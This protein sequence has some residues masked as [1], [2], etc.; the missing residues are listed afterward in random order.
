MSSMP[1]DSGKPVGPTVP[2]YESESVEGRD[3]LDIERDVNGLASLVAA[4]QVTPPLSIGL[5]GPWGSG[6]SFFMAKLRTRISQLADATRQREARA[7][8]S[9]FHG[10]VVQI[11]FNA[12]NYIEADLWASLVTHI[13]EQLHHR[14]V[15]HPTER[16]QWFKLLQELDDAEETYGETQR[17]REAA[18]SALADAHDRFAAV[19]LSLVKRIDVWWD[20]V[21]RGDAAT[22]DAISDELNT[23]QAGLG[24]DAAREILRD[25]ARHREDFERI[26]PRLPSFWRVAAANFWRVVGI[27]VVAVCIL[28]TLAMIVLYALAQLPPGQAWMREFWAQVVQAAVPIVAAG[29]SI[30][31]TMAKVVD[32]NKR[33]ER[34]RGFAQVEL[35]AGKAKRPEA[36]ALL[37]AERQLAVAAADHEEQQRTVDQL[38]QEERAMR[39]S[40]RLASFLEDRAGSEDYRKYLGVPAMIRRDF[41]KLH[42]LLVELREQSFVLPADEAFW[43]DLEG[44]STASDDEADV[45]PSV[46]ELVD[47]T[48]VRLRKVHVQRQGAEAEPV[49]VVREVGRPRTI[50]LRRDGDTARGEI[51]WALPRIDRI[52]LYI[53]D[54]DRCPA[55]RV[56][57]VLQ[58]VHM[59]L[60]F[61]LFVVVVGV[62]ARWISSSLD[63]EHTDLFAMGSV[64]PHDYLEKI[65]QIPYWIEPIT[66][67]GATQM[68][69]HFLAP[70]QDRDALVEP[71]PPVELAGNE[72]AMQAP[73]LT[74]HEVEI[75]AVQATAGLVGR[76]P[77]AVKRYLNAYR[78]LRTRLTPAELEQFVVGDAPVPDYRL[79]VVLLAVMVGAPGVAS[80]LFPKIRDEPA[81]GRLEAAAI[82]G[83]EADCSV[84]ER[85]PSVEL[86]LRELAV[87]GG[88]VTYGRLHAVLAQV[89]RLSFRFATPS[90][91]LGSA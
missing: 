52:V 8:K 47:S 20:A 60:T 22:N 84:Q 33:V 6:K 14:F 64:H 75:E 38:R 67:T 70:A 65:F 41:E 57:E 90:P 27:A 13:F 91:R 88:G 80:V 73:Q 62:D 25:I 69:G 4:R 34:I 37:E 40:E 12:W 10:H 82:D 3:L 56:V 19:R 15:P 32:I 26:R 17:A 2:H 89:S 30:Q 77:R 24:D 74:L 71:T 21:A 46:R 72:E 54:L 83:W 81:E 31:Q 61:P 66:K 45:P 42:R 87:P 53:D 86:A 16:E 43:Q 51:E 29:T 58:A 76:S 9:S 63:K 59:L 68:L 1:T 50:T 28:A 55:D 23:L 49:Y 79:A 35:A 36:A 5:F 85:W 18:E 44:K 39:P 48:G 11:K 78:L 7:L